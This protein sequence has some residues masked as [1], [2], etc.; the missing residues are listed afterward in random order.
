MAGSLSSARQACASA[1]GLRGG[2]TTPVSPIASVTPPT[3]VATHGR[4]QVIASIRV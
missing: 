3:S 2:T 1:S 4:P